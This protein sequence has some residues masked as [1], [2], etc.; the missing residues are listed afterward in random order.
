[1]HLTTNPTRGDNSYQVKTQGTAVFWN[2]HQT[3]LFPTWMCRPSTAPSPA[4]SFSAP[5]LHPIEKGEWEGLGGCGA[6]SQGNPKRM[7]WLLPNQHPPELSASYQTCRQCLNDT[8]L[9]IGRD[10]KGTDGSWS[11]HHRRAHTV[12]HWL[13]QKR[14]KL[15]PAWQPFC[16]S[17][18]YHLFKCSS[19]LPG[20]GSYIYHLKFFM[21]SR[22]NTSFIKLE[23]RLI[24]T[25]FDLFQEPEKLSIVVIFWAV[26]FLREI[27]EDFPIA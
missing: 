9:S 15:I 11:H 6:A 12:W 18:L 25:S 3:R 5:C 1:M 27:A 24:L 14:A 20:C 7:F 10:K 17:S 13:A 23:A 19:N 26:I 22:I 4:I 21:S 2:W 16:L 8:T